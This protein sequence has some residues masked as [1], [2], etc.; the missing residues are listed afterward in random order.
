[1][2][3]IAVVLVIAMVFGSGPAWALSRTLDNAVASHK[4]SEL[5]PVADAARITGGVNHGLH[6]MTDPI[7]DNGGDKVMEPVR[8]VKDESVKGARTIVNETWKMLSRPFDSLRK[9]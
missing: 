6:M 2:K 9:E 8:M 3:K 1:M 4:K 7:M 5:A